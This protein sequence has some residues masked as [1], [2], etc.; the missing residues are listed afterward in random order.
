MRPALI[1]LVGAVLLVAV[2]LAEIYV[3][4][5]VFVLSCLTVILILAGT[6][7]PMHSRSGQLAFSAA[8]PGSF[9]PEWP[10]LE[11]TKLD[12]YRDQHLRFHIEARGFGCLRAGDQLVGAAH[13]THVHV[14]ESEL[15]RLTPYGRRLGVG[16]I[17]AVRCIPDTHVTCPWGSRGA[18]ED[19][20]RR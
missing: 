5:I 16:C 11:D 14:H 4:A 8:E 1:M 7:V 17:R 20:Q 13:R 6:V 3:A 10:C 9:I 2:F 15:H 18:T 12:P 19:H